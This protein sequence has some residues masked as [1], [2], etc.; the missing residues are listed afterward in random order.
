MKI[1]EVP[2]KVI[3]QGLTRMQPRDRRDETEELQLI[4]LPIEKI[5][6]EIA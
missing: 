3:I 5:N 1:P 4:I 2:D 6:Q